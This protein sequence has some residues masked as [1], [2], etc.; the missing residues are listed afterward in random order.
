[1]E[2][3]CRTLRF[4]GCG[5]SRAQPSAA[6]AEPQ[7]TS[8]PPPLKFCPP[9]SL[10]MGLSLEFHA[11][12]LLLGYNRTCSNFAQACSPAV[13]AC[14]RYWRDRLVQKW[15]RHSWLCG[16]CF[17]SFGVASKREATPPVGFTMSALHS[18]IG[19]RESWKIGACQIASG[20]YLVSTL[21]QNGGRG[22]A[23]LTSLLRVRPDLSLAESYRCTQNKHN[24]FRMLFLQKKVGGTPSL[25]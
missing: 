18:R 14:L 25:K 11:P 23:T 24:S 19:N 4:Q 6:L 22:S 20:S 8:R 15:H 10:P 17:R 9:V 16:Y 5:F 3:G 21:A 7:T 13:L 1:L 2:V 12:H